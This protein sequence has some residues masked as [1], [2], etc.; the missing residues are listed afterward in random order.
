MQRMNSRDLQKSPLNQHKQVRNN[1]FWLTQAYIGT[2][3][4]GQGQSLM[5]IHGIY[6]KGKKGA[7]LKSE[8]LMLDTRLSTARVFYPSGYMAMSGDNFGCHNWVKYT[9]AT[10]KLRPGMM[11]LNILMHKLASTMKNYSAPNVN[12]DKVENPCPRLN[13]FLV[14]SN[15]P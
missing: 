1:Y 6:I 13:P 15:K 7:C 8:D 11:P 14:P 5:I 9:T 12:S 10:S 4:N 2:T 3:P